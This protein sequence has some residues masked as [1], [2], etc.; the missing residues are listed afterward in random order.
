MNMFSPT[1]VL[2]SR[3]Q[4]TPVQLVPGSKGYLLQ[5]EQEWQSGK[6]PAF[7][8]NSR[9]GFFCRSIPVV[10]YSLQPIATV[11]GEIKSVAAAPRT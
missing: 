1:H 9:R 5:T 7:E 6:T 10:G 11:T 2:V 4:Q 8:M 3:S